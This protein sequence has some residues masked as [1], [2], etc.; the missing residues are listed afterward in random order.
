MESADGA[1]A[2]FGEED[3]LECRAADFA[4][5]ARVQIEPDGLEQVTMR[6]RVQGDLSCD[7][8][9]NG[10]I[11]ETHEHLEV[12]FSCLIPFCWRN[13]MACRIMLL[14]NR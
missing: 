11:I 1:V 13:F 7:R 6:L 9:Y 5:A 2:Q 12:H 3:V 14:V 8:N 4:L 10:N